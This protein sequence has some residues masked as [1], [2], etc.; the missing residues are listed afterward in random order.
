MTLYKLGTLV[1]GVIFS[2]NTFSCESLNTKTNADQLNQREATSELSSFLLN[3]NHELSKPTDSVPKI[4]CY[5][6][7]KNLTNPEFNGIANAL[8]DLG[9]TVNSNPSLG[10][11]HNVINTINDQIVRDAGTGFVLFPSATGTSK[12][13]NLFS[14][15]ID[16]YCS[17]TS[18]QRCAEKT[19]IAKQLW[20]IAGEYRG[21][22]DHLNRKEKAA[23][24]AF[25][26]TL[27]QQWRSYKDDTI[28]LWPQEVLLNSLVYGPAKKSLS[29]PPRYK[30]LGL[31]P[32]LGLT[33]LSDQ[34]HKIQPTLNV[35]LLGVYWWHYGEKA[36]TGGIKAQPGQGISVS[37]IWDG[38]DTALGLTYH[39]NPKWS[40]TLAHGTENNVIV[41]I[42]FQLAHWLL[43]H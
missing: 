31:R 17:E 1:L 19:D 15:F 40:L 28:K 27:N 25:N 8:L 42:S 34:S 18:S 20:W 38:S 35:D 37:L 2:T 9:V 13:F 32:S 12:E 14:E 24:L 39:H 43:K 30:L 16:K 7:E 33:Y 11:K 5:L 6:N 22:P 21:Y 23:S 29:T 26:Q 3:T 10:K 41:S 4:N 36:Q